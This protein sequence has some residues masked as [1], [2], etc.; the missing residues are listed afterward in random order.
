[1]PD[2]HSLTVEQLEEL[3]AKHTVTLFRK[4][5]GN[6][7]Q[8]YRRA[9][10]EKLNRPKLPVDEILTA[11]RSTPNPEEAWNAT[12]QICR[13][14]APTAPWDKLPTPN[15]RQDIVNAW[16]WL[17]EE[18][19]TLGPV[20]GIYLGLDTLNMGE[21]DG[22][23]IEIGATT[24]CDP[25]TDSTDWVRGELTHGGVH[26]ICG[27]YEMHQVYSQ[28]AWRVKDKTIAQGSAFSFADYILFLAYSGIVLT[29]AFVRLRLTRPVLPVWGFHDGD[30]FILGRTMPEGFQ[31][32]CQ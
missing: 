15:F 16:S 20:T 4:V 23:N 6:D 3:C 28:E 24:K 29:H 9:L 17:R 12:L 11:L 30:L 19:E 1:M 25:F 2:Y 8:A 10:L 26:H 18:L 22:P 32:I 14:S 27:L 7:P 21:G 31:L 5:H 13:H